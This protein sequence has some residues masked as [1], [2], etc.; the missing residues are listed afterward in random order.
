MSQSQVKAA[1]RLGQNNV[2]SRR[3]AFRSSSF[4]A[5]RSFVNTSL[6]LSYF[7]SVFVTVYHS[8]SLDTTTPLVD[9]TLESTL[10]DYPG[11]KHAHYGDYG[12]SYYGE[13]SEPPPGFGEEDFETGI[14]HAAPVN[15]VDIEEPVVQF[16]A[17]DLSSLPPAKCKRCK[18]TFASRNK[19]HKHIQNDC[20]QRPGTTTAGTADS[21]D[22]ESEHNQSAYANE[23]DSSTEASK[24][25]N[26]P[27]VKSSVNL[28]ADI[29]TRFGFRNW[30]KRS[31]CRLTQTRPLRYVLTQAAPLHYATRT[32]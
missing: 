25:R 16:T 13:A 21:S 20:C 28:K 11:H 29:G 3:R 31:C 1:H 2:F 27:L 8:A 17:I 6:L 22:S 23:V 4:L 19:L 7:R 18:A 9:Q 12:N 14:Y 26:L 32:G 15:T 10:S 30:Y 5:F 24:S